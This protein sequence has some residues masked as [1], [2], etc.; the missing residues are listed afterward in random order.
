MSEINQ[1]T[2][3]EKPASAHILVIDDEPGFRVLLQQELSKRGYQVTTAVNGEDA[4]EK[5]RQGK[6]QL[7]I[8]DVKMPKMGGLE[9][10]EALKKDNPQ[11]EVIMATG[12]GT[13]ETA[14]T[15]MK[16]GA[17]DFVQKPFNLEE[18]LALIEKALEKSEL[19]AIIGV[20]EASK[21]IF[22]SIKLDTLLPIIMQLALKILKADDASLMLMGNDGKLALAASSG[23]KDDQR[24]E[25][26]L[27]LGERVAGKAAQ[28]QEPLLITGRLEDDPRFTG[29]PHLR[30]IQSAVVYPLVVSGE[31]LGVLNANRVS[32]SDPFNASD[33]YTVTIFGSQIAQ[34]VNNARLYEKLELKVGELKVAYQQL[35][36]TQLQLAQTEKLA[37]IGQLAA[38]VAHELNNP[39][40]GIMGFSEIVL[41]NGDLPPQVREDIES[42][43]KQSKR[44]RQIIQNLLQFS[45]RK[46]SHK[47]PTDLVPLLKSTLQLVR[48][49]FTTSGIDIDEQL[50]VASAL[51]FADPAQLQQVFLNLV[52]NARQA[53]EKKRPAKLT[54]RLKE[55]PD[56]V[57]LSFQ[58]TGCGVSKENLGKVFDPFFT[59]KP[60]GQGT[61]LG[62]SISYGII[63]QHQGAIR[64]E[65]EE[66]AGTTFR[67]ELPIHQGDSDE[68]KE[69][70][71]R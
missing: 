31:L 16:R 6:F 69:D 17:Y 38:G 54:I 56:K 1:N 50:P 43:Y 57:E 27:A 51:V 7:A 26:R 21:A 49:D 18:I 62:L 20:Y 25:A 60:V 53:M 32:Q 61:G 66:G 9:F 71:D 59:T 29:I 14:V 63:Q 70:I 36:E 24:R 42:I 48:Y 41:E 37:A 64:V 19:K 39:L 10:L 33:L 34:A 67:L 4:L 46:E 2:S 35:E 47:E 44:C 28:W 22:A 3:G 65:S 5:V 12:F 23:L 45:R 15:A 13:I 52:T 11:I 58:D 55:A 8:S 30:D 40:T 68:S